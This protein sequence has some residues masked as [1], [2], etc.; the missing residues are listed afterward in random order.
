MSG[1]VSDAQKHTDSTT[2]KSATDRVRDSGFKNLKDVI[3]MALVSSIG[4]I[5]VHVIRTTNLLLS[6]LSTSCEVTS[7]T[8]PS[9]VRTIRTSS[10]QGG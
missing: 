2:S 10:N 3:E 6:C 8:V 9:C 4:S 7:S 1:A 5:K